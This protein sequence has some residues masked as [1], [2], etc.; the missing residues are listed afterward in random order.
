VIGGEGHK[1][2]WRC[3]FCKKEHTSGGSRVTSHFL[4][5]ASGASGWGLVCTSAEGCSGRLSSLQRR[6]SWVC[7]REPGTSRRNPSRSSRTRRGPCRLCCSSVTILNLNGLSAR[8]DDVWNTRLHGTRTKTNCIM[9]T[10]S[11][12]P[13]SFGTSVPY[14]QIISPDLSV[15]QSLSRYKQGASSAGGKVQ[16]V[17]ITCLYYWFRLRSGVSPPHSVFCVGR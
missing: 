2:H 1:T 14:L 7:G 15:T 12:Y 3:V 13:L 17:K 10:N 16:V 9:R 5:K 8:W 4:G 11:F 6:K